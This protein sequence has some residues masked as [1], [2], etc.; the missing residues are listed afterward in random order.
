[1]FAYLAQNPAQRQ[2]IV[3]DP[4][5]IPSAVEELL[6]WETPVTIVPRVTVRD[7]EVA[8]CPFHKGENVA[9]VI[10]SAN[11]DEEGLPDAYTVD[12]TRNPNK[13]L[14]FGGGVHRCLGSHL[15][16]TELRIALREWHRRIP[17]YSIK[18]GTKL[19]YMFGLRQLDELPLVFGA[20]GGA[21]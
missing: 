3:D 13:H 17:D 8:G 21:G 7:I 2:R 1:M 14:A 16:R 12:L 5:I 10:G 15:A 19:N 20:S 6:R 11:T 4:S 18:P 9:V